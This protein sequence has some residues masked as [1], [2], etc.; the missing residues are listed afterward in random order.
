MKM[1]NKLP[2][3]FVLVAMMGLLLWLCERGCR[4][5]ER[6]P[7]PVSAGGLAVTIPTAQSNALQSEKEPGQALSSVPVT[8]G[9][10]IEKPANMS[11]ADWMRVP[12]YLDWYR[13][14][15]ARIDF[16]G[17]IVDQNSNGVAGVRIRVRIPFFP[18]PVKY[19]IDKKDTTMLDLTSDASGLF[20]TTGQ[21][22][23]L[24][25]IKAMEKEGYEISGR[26]HT[27]FY[28]GRHYGDGHHPDSTK[29]VVFQMWKKGVPEALIQNLVQFK[30]LEKSNYSIDLIS[31]KVSNHT[32]QNADLWI[33]VSSD[34]KGARGNSTLCLTVPSG[35]LIETSNTY[36]YLAPENGYQ[37]TIEWKFHSHV[38]KKVYLTSRNGKIYCAMEIEAANDGEWWVVLEN[39]VNPKGSR[40]LEDDPK[41]RIRGPALKALIREF[42]SNP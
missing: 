11:D 4:R 22:G 10:K 28:Y 17:K 40:N 31:G 15:N 6:T 38:T 3:L 14:N 19:M 25:D 12:K 7:A 18:E 24:L 34:G 23:S 41:K 29:P 36:L 42:D 26:T 2:I 13:A 27:I 8:N 9:V 5:H 32:N 37:T 1:K 39:R 30:P 35:G 16:Y 20:V 21:T 33:N